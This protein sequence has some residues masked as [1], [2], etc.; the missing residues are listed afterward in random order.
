MLLQ[1]QRDCARSPKVARHELPWVFPP[2]TANPNG[3]VPV[4]RPSPRPVSVLKRGQ[5]LVWWVCRFANLGKG[6]KT[7]AGHGNY[8]WIILDKAL[9][10]EGAGGYLKMVCD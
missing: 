5:V 6:G 9:V 1:S 3:V 8:E 4:G 10:V 2:T 7:G